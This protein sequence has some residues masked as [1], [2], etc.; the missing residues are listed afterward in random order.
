MLVD[1]R[2]GRKNQES[3]VSS[4]N[5]QPHQGKHIKMFFTENQLQSTNIQSKATLEEYK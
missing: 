2:A 5:L 3:D 4:V 1:N